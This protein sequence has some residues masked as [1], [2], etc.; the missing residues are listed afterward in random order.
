MWFMS[1]QRV[2]L[3]ILEV[4]SNF[5]DSMILLGEA[6]A[7]QEKPSS[8]HFSSQDTGPKLDCLSGKLQGKADFGQ[9]TECGISLLCS[10]EAIKTS[11]KNC[12]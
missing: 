2:D 7:G 4:L 6:T 3:I 10:P 5:N 9:E 1:L 11:G 12:R 8:S